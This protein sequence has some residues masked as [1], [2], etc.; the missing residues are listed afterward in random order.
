MK[1]ESQGQFRLSRYLGAVVP[2]ALVAA[3]GLVV[4]GSLFGAGAILFTTDNNIGN[5]A[6]AKWLLPAGIAGAWSS[7]PLLGFGGAQPANW[8]N[9]WLYTLPLP[10]Y[11]NWIHYLDLVVASVFFILTL[12][13]RGLGFT[14]I[15]VGALVAFW[16]G[17][18]FCLVYAGHNGKF[19]VLA[20]MAMALFCIQEA[21]RK[22]S[23]AWAV[24]AGGAM[25]VALLEQQ[26]VTLFFGL[27]WAPYALFLLVREYGWQWSMLLKILVPMTAAVVLIGG[28][29][30]LGVYVSQTSGVS[31]GAGETHESKWEFVTQWSLPPDE[32]I[33]L[34]APGY[35]GWRS[36]EAEGPYWGRM[37]RSEGWEKTRQGF[38]N[39]KLDD[40]YMGIVAIV[41]PVLAIVGAFAWRKGLNRPLPDAPPGTVQVLMGYGRSEV[42][43][44]G[45][46]ALVAFLLALGKYF[47]LYQ[48]FYQLPI[49]NNIRAPV[50][51][52]QVMQ[53]ALG[54]LAAYGVEVCLCYNGQR[55]KAT[56]GKEG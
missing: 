30:S 17:T 14:S 22:R 39:F 37:G 2:V 28:P 36:G 13:R 33:A 40:G 25:G 31:A 16:I 10:F 15:I 42:L 11:I 7:T 12:T 9:F 56:I 27:F 35:M 23:V 3:I 19:A 1:C 48:V 24:L 29:A 55:S 26:D 32:S 6:G 38:M 4:F 41:F 49:V 53:F 8:T 50:K 5:E 34:I 44:W 21:V 45:A 43:F 52:I 47:P 18:N 20:F 54:I 51:F 46:V